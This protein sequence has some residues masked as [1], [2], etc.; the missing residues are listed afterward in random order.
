MDG[1]RSR[2]TTPPPQRR[3]VSTVGR[4]HSRARKRFDADAYSSSR[5][6]TRRLRTRHAHVRVTTSPVRVCRPTTR[7]A[8]EHTRD[9]A[10]RLLLCASPFVGGRR[11]GV[12]RP[13]A[14]ALR[15]EPI[16]RR[17]RAD[18]GRAT[19]A[20]R[21]HSHS[22]RHSSAVHGVNPNAVAFP[23]LARDFFLNYIVPSNVRRWWWRTT[24]GTSSS[25]TER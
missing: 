16:G 21:G 4:R 15:R 7:C 18:A 22:R 5:R 11:V 23:R 19:Q 17:F 8:C 1:E 9:C 24:M 2:S 25:S 12:R 10:S 20:I 13:N 14:V 3:R 6:Y